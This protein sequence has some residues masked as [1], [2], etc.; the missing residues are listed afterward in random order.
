MNAEQPGSQ[1]S[2]ECGAH[3]D[4]LFSVTF[5]CKAFVCIKLCILRKCGSNIVRKCG[6]QRAAEMF[7]SN[8]YFTDSQKSFSINLKLTTL[9]IMSVHTLQLF[10][11]IINLTLIAGY[12]TITEHDIHNLRVDLREA[13]DGSTISTPEA[14]VIQP[15]LASTV[16]LAFHDCSGRY[17]DYSGISPTVTLNTCDGCLDFSNSD[18]YDLEETAYEPLEDIYQLS[19]HE[20]YSKM[21]RADFWMASG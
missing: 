6:I 5:W 17:V 4:L 15:L 8:I 11:I 12:S 1:R 19:D 2:T 13:F 16:K 7:G 18:N 3:L 9:I 14:T 20:W 10:A 21:S